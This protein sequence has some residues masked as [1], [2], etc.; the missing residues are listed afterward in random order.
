MVLWRAFLDS[1]LTF[2]LHFLLFSAE[3]PKGFLPKYFELPDFLEPW[4][5]FVFKKLKFYFLFIIIFAI[6]TMTTWTIYSSCVTFA[7][8]LNAFGLFTITF[9][10]LASILGLAL[11]FVYIFFLLFNYVN[12]IY[13]IICKTTSI[14][15]NLNTSS[16]SKNKLMLFIYFFIFF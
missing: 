2:W 12:W 11:F 3:M 4:F 15:I 10:L 1:N 13:I 7:I 9:F 8:Q 6:N 16:L 5:V 14:L